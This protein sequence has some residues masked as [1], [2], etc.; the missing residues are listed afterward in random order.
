MNKLRMLGFATL[1]MAIASS[2]GMGHDIEI[3]TKGPG[4]PPDILKR[5]QLE[6]GGVAVLLDLFKKGDKGGPGFFLEVPFSASSDEAKLLTT[7]K[8][9]QEVEKYNRLIFKITLEDPKTGQAKAIRPGI[10]N[11]CTP[12][13]DDKIHPRD[14]SVPLFKDDKK[15]VSVL[16]RLKHTFP[17][18]PFGRKPDPKII[19]WGQTNC[20]VSPT[21][22]E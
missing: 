14:G 19:D 3:Y 6:G 7:W 18:L 2:A 10:G 22:E 4:V 15:L 20:F 5:Y 21:Y 13:Y 12:I 11:Y 1:A 9:N 17:R 16:I 8:V